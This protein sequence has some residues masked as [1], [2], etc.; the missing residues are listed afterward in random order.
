MMPRKSSGEPGEF[1]VL[2]GEVDVEAISESVA[3]L[4][5]AVQQRLEPGY[6][7]AAELM[8]QVFAATISKADLHSPVVPGEEPGAIARN[9]AQSITTALSNLKPL[10]AEL[11]RPCREGDQK[12]CIDNFRV[13]RLIIEGGLLSSTITKI[14]KMVMLSVSMNSVIPISKLTDAWVYGHYISLVPRGRSAFP[15]IEQPEQ[16]AQQQQAQQQARQR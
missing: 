1:Q 14:G 5:P 2:S 10:V 4:L 3:S 8:N 6:S 12:S 9:F 11:M 13:S 15:S 7:R 16:Q